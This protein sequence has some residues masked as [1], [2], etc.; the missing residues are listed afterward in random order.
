MRIRDDGRGL[1]SDDAVKPGHYD[2]VGMRERA[3][4]AG[5]RL[6]LVSLPGEGTTVEFWIP[7][8]DGG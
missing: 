2:V 3:E 1:D 5:G 7:L 4:D 6:E 8:P